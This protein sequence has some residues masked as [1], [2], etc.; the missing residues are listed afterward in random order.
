VLKNPLDLNS[1][2]QR[3][4]REEAQKEKNGLKCVILAGKPVQRMG[5]LKMA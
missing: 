2:V 4:K 5:L 1:K 3:I